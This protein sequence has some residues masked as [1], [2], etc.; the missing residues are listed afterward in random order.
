[1]SKTAKTVKFKTELTV[2]STGSGMHFLLVDK[3]IE[4]KFG[5]EGKSKRVVCSINGGEPFQCALMP[6]GDT[7]YII[8]NKKKRDEVGIATGDVVNVALV[9]DDSKYGLPMPEELR[10]VLNQDPAGDKL[11]HALTAGKQRSMLYYVGKIKDVDQRI[12][13]ALIIVDHIKENEGK[14]ID[15]LLYEELKRPTLTF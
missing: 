5:F 6:W 3:A 15:K 8:V 10:E 12:H 14:V 11:F 13:A 7:F 9:K 1:M 2:S 4:A